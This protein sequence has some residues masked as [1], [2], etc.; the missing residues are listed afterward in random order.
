MISI[1]TYIA[2][3]LTE[4]MLINGLIK[5]SERDIYK[6]CIQVVV[7][8][9]IG[10]SIILFLSIIWGVF[11]ETV[12]FLI[13]FSTLRKYTGG[14]H[15]HSFT[16]C[17]I[18]TLAIYSLFV[19]F[20]C[21]IIQKN[22]NTNMIVFI[23]AGIIVFIIGAVN[24]PNMEWN[25]QEYDECKKIARVVTAMQLC[26]VTTLSYLGMGDTYILFMSFGMILCSFLMTLGKIMKQEVKGDG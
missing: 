8:K 21:P 17:L 5:P 15:A 25:K 18:G 26:I 4:H 19:K 3:S 20:L 11:I 2:H 24:H 12:L 10:F 23:A 7:E 22:I 13:C 14:F 9:I 1:T 16:G 6:Y